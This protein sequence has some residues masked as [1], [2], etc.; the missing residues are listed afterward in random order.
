MT[1]PVLTPEQARERMAQGAVLVDVRNDD[2][3]RRA[4]IA[5]AVHAPLTRLEQNGLPEAAQSASV[6]VFHCK[7][8][9]R[10][11]SAAD[12]LAGFAEADKREVFVLSGGL[13][14]WKQA[15]LPVREDA[16]QPLELMRQ[17][18]IA[19]GSMVLGGVLLG[20]LVSPVFYLLSGFVGAGLIFAGVSGCCMLARLLAKMPW[21]T[22]ASL[23]RK[24]GS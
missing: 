16:S 13:D 17:V 20:W 3:Y 4:H 11:Q 18:Q 8:G 14:A 7:S 5:E 24:H 15:G 23:G 2:E 6:L 12:L 9:M 19:A 21:N 1:L 22:K 10:T